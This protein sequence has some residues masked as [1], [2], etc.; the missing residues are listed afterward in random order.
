MQAYS[1]SVPRILEVILALSTTDPDH[2]CDCYQFLGSMVEFSIY[3]LIPHIKPII[4][5]SAQL[6]GNKNIDDT[7]RCNGLNLISTIIR[8][9][10][11]VSFS[12][13]YIFNKFAFCFRPY[14]ISV[15]K[16]FSLINFTTHHIFLLIRP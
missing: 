5:V 2:A 11:K 8:C 15:D 10:K 3:A 12:P 1:Q 13:Y 9:K 4:Q 6:A 7:L 16:Y 14:T